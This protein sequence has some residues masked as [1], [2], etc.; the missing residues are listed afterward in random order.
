MFVLAGASRSGVHSAQTAV[1]RGLRS[2]EMML[3]KSGNTPQTARSGR[4]DSRGIVTGNNTA[5]SK[6]SISNIPVHVTEHMQR[7]V[8]RR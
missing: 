4:S 5:E 2:R 8:A 6:Y 7:A 1:W 3:A